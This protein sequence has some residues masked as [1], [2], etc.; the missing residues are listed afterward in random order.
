MERLAF[1]STSTADLIDEL[2]HR[3]RL[4]EARRQADV[5][6]TETRRRLLRRIIEA[7]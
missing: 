2:R 5:R 4:A 7:R 6:R 1:R 3:E